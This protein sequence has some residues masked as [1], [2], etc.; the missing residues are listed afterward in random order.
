MTTVETSG[1]DQSNEFFVFLFSKNIPFKI[2]QK[3][4]KKEKRKEKKR[5]KFIDWRRVDE[6]ENEKR[7]EKIGR[8]SGYGSE[9]G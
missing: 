1:R 6:K 9:L 5:G 7:T 3:S 4:E 8:M 2:S